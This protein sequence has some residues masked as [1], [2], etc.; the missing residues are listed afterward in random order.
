MSDLSQDVS[1]GTLLRRA[2]ESAGLH[3][4]ALAVALKVPVRKLEALEA[5]RYDDLP[6]AVFARALAS[7]VC[8]NLKIDPQPVLARLPQTAAPRLARTQDSINA[9][10]RAPGDTIGSGWKEQLRRPMPLAVIALLLGAV[11]LIFLPDFRPETTTTAAAAKPEP[12]AAPM[13]APVVLQPSNEP[14]LAA[15][16]PVIATSEAPLVA[17]S[18]APLAQAPQGSPGPGVSPSSSVPV[19]A[20]PTAAGTSAAAAS[21]LVVFRT[22]GPSWIQVT[23]ARGTVTLRRQLEAGES[24]GASGQ[25]PLSVTVGSAGATRVDVRGKAFDLAPVTRDNVARFEVK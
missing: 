1:A 23:D 9:P 10:F 18:A 16:A 13:A 14:A 15:T 24:V 20:T 8:R 4:A 19:G 12:A 6:D 11:L 17:P 7:S 2:R 22:S 5:D 25:L 3:V 21:G